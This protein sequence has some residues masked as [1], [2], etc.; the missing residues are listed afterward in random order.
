AVALLY[1]IG[2]A[3]IEQDLD[4]TAGKDPLARIRGLALEAPDMVDDARQ[5][6]RAP[7]GERPR[8]RPGPGSHG[9][10]LQAR[11]SFSAPA[12][13]RVKREG[14]PLEGRRRRVRCRRR[15]GRLANRRDWRRPSAMVERVA[16][17]KLKPEHAT[18][19]ARSAI[20][21]RALAELA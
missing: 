3:E 6:S 5:L 7:R 21:Q 17:I 4:R 15:S 20:V 11:V 2:V 10:D 1:A 8:A 13:A 16:L 12:R 19:A 14:R 18:P 9:F